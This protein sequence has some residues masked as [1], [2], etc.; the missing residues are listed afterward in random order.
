MLKFDLSDI[1][2]DRVSGASSLYLRTLKLLIDDP[3]Y[4]V[5][6]RRD[7]ALRRLRETFPEMAVFAYLQK[8]FKG[9]GADSLAAVL[10][11]LHDEAEAEPAEIGRRLDRIWKR[12]RRIVTFSHSSLV[13][14]LL[15]ERRSRIDQLLISTAAPNNEG[16]IAAAR[17][18][19][20]G[21][22]VCLSA[23]A[24][25]PGL[26]R[27][28][29]FI[30]VGADTVAER[31]FVNK[32]GTVPLLLTAH[33]VGAVSL[34]VFE[35]FKQTAARD[36]SFEPRQHPTSEILLGPKRG[37]DIFNAYFETIPIAYADWLLS[38]DGAFRGRKK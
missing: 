9:V 1:L 14:R 28:G 35:R 22:D 21:V 27:R 7:R 11:R 32:C 33:A 15:L 17:Y 3:L 4:R 6:S 13:M 37:I 38:G 8:K 20:A 19:S 12:K 23:D 16:A 30:V 10:E 2:S 31:F 18:A 26:V 5:Q 36:Y 24:A 34:V 29:D 25:L